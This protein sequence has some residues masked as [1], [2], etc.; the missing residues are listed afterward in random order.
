MGGPLPLCLHALV[1]G[2]AG[3]LVTA[4]CD[5][6]LLPRSRKAPPACP[7][8]CIQ[9]PCQPRIVRRRVQQHHHGKVDH[10]LHEQVSEGLTRPLVGK[11]RQRHVRRAL[12]RRGE[13][14][15]HRAL[16]YDRPQ[17]RNESDGEERLVHADGG[18]QPEERA[19]QPVGQAGVWRNAVAVWEILG[20]PVACRGELCRR[21]VVDDGEDEKHCGEHT[22]TDKAECEHSVGRLRVVLEQERHEVGECCHGRPESSEHGGKRSATVALQHHAEAEAVQRKRHTDCR[23]DVHQH[24]VGEVGHPVVEVRGTAERLQLPRTCLALLHDKVRDARG[25]EGQAEGDVDGEHEDRH[26]LEAVLLLLRLGKGVHRH[27]DA[28]L[29]AQARESRVGECGLEGGRRVGAGR[30]HEDDGLRPGRPV[31]R[32]SCARRAEHVVSTKASTGTR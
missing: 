4:W 7:R 6:W 13:E 29:H 19:Q 12:A 28:P 22:C 2:T 26:L 5:E 27:R 14:R 3:S 24:V 16:R 9:E 30:V 18:H 10:S 17:V 23:H 21:V 25:D 1:I 8:R 11:R 15:L 31:R 32:V 20:W